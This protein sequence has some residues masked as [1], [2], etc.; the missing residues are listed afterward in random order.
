MRR[1]F[2]VTLIALL[3]GVGVVAIIETDPGYVLVSY[4]HYTL[5]TSL[6]VGLLLLLVLVLVVFW[7]VRLVYRLV[8]GQRTFMSWLG[9]RK[10]QLAQR[11]STR[12]VIHYVE[13]NLDRARRQLERGLDKN[14]APLVNYLLA[15][16][17]A[18]QAGQ[19][20]QALDNLRLA[21]E[22]EP[23]AKVA[24]EV[25]L[26]EIRLRNK[27]YSQALAALKTGRLHPGRHPRVLDILY[28]C[29]EG[30]G[31][32][33]AM[34]ELLPELKK[35]K[36]LPLDEFSALEESVHKH[37][38]SLAAGS[39]ADN[40]SAAWQQVPARLRQN[41]ALLEAHVGA[42]AQAGDPERAGKVVLKAL[43]QEW[44]P[45]LVRQF[46]LL[47]VDND[48]S[49]KRLSQAERWLDGHGDDL[50]L[51]L[52]L[53]RL[54]ARDQLWG[55]ARD[56]FEQAYRLSATSEVCAE[57]GR[58]LTAMGETKVAAAYFR[59]GLLQ[60]ADGLPELP[61]PDKLVSDGQLAAGS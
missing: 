59:E 36:R 17:A 41:P 40:V 10:S 39:S 34:L 25:T 18:D 54:S 55:K 9:N 7:A 56:Y 13:G 4:S 47:A 46:G 12:G 14:E 24:V 11:H 58:L 21:G 49:F 43:K 53:G 35:S 6:W 31:D 28:Q 50:E 61:M 48:S 44:Q 20:A 26:A 30:L 22:S 52:C 51:L 27:E 60:S 42:L 32:W 2:A 38:L 23:A 15:A 37:R 45:S 5:E 1:L 19:P 33:D 57:L 8:G 29:Y 16:R 3:M